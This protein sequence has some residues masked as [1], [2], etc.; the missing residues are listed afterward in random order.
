MAG[1]SGTFQSAVDA[2][3][4]VDENAINTFNVAGAAPSCLSQHVQKKEYVIIGISP[5]DFIKEHDAVSFDM[6][7]LT[8]QFT[9]ICHDYGKPLLMDKSSMAVEFWSKI[10]YEIG[11]ESRQVK[12]K[13]SDRI[14][15]M[16]FVY[17]MENKA[18]VKTAYIATFK[19]ETKSYQATNEPNKIVLTIRQAGLLAL[20]ILAMINEL[21]AGSENYMLTPLAGAVFSKAYIPSIAA[22]LRESEA[23]VC[24]VINASCQSGGQYLIESS[25]MVA[26]ISTIVSTRN[27]KEQSIKDSIIGKTLKQYIKKFLLDKC[28]YSLS[29]YNN[30]RV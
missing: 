11:P 13:E 29:E 15:K 10:I 12:K 4:I 19:N 3:K 26:V 2:L 1:S 8:E 22:K 7:E 16:R 6:A 24:N 14:W 30:F 25:P 21:T 27:M 5:G 28:F 23:Q 17:N 18:V 9:K 20:N